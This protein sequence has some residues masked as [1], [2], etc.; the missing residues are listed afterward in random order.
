MKVLPFYKDLVLQYATD[1]AEN[2][3]NADVISKLK[4]Q[5]VQDIKDLRDRYPELLYVNYITALDDEKASRLFDK[6]KER[7]KDKYSISLLPDTLRI[8]DNVNGD[9]IETPCFIKIENGGYICIR[10]DNPELKKAL[11]NQILL[12]LVIQ[13]PI[14]KIEFT[15]V[16]LFGKYDEEFLLKILIL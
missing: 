16:D 6:I 7:V 14:K 13:L 10:Y 2:Q 4:E 3:G 12:H 15:F 8:D 11:I 9:Q 5:F 1:V